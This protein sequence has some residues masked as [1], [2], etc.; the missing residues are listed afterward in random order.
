MFRPLLHRLLALLILTLGCASH[1]PVPE[2]GPI[3]PETA[4]QLLAQWNSLFPP[5]CTLS[6][7]IVLKVGGRIYDFTGAAA[8]R[9][10]DHFRIMALGDMGGL[11]FDFLIADTACSIIKRPP[12]MPPAPLHKGVCS[13][14][15]FLYGLKSGRTS[16]ARLDSGRL[17]CSV[18]DGEIKHTCVFDMSF[19]PIVSYSVKGRRRIR[20]VTYPGSGPPDI[21]LS[22][23]PAKMVLVNHRWHYRMEIET[24]RMQPSIAG[25]TVFQE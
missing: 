3:P 10:P 8:I 7:R 1:L 25:N 12:G 22:N 17:S 11:V 5:E 6:Q 13:D 18:T 20:T 23:I 21:A 16:S 19:R 14:I 24:S 4:D 9:K 2:A 15:I